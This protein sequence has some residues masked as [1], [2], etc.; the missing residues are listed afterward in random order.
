MPKTSSLPNGISKNRSLFTLLT[1]NQLGGKKV[2]LM[3]AHPGHK[4]GVE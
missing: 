2:F 3:R 1:Q 4:D